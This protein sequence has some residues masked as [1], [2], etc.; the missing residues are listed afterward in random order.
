VTTTYDAEAPDHL[1]YKIVGGSSAIIIGDRRWDRTPGSGWK[2]SVQE[3]I[4]QPTP[5]W[6]PQPIDAH[7]LGT[8]RVAGHTALLISF[9][10][11]ETVGFFTIAVDRKTLRTLA[12]TLT[13][14]AH[15]M[16]HRYSDFNAPITIKPPR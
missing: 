4:K 9:Y 8:T 5:A 14:A 3:P 2:L 12:L 11:P 1:T 10:D 13:A 6:G 7:L 15:F 16:H